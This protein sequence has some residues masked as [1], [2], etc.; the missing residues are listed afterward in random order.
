M[1][2][3]TSFRWELENFFSALRFPPAGFKQWSD[4]FELDGLFGA[5]FRLAFLSREPSN[6]SCSIASLKCVQFDDHADVRLC[7]KTKCSVGF[8]LKKALI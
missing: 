5:P 8:D 6:P 1:P 4:I 3:I 7:F 2:T